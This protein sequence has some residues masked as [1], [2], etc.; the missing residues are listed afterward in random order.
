MILEEMTKKQ[1]KKE[2]S[3]SLYYG[4]KTTA[5]TLA[6]AGMGVAAGIAGIAVAAAVGEIILPVALCLWSTGVAGGALG[7]LLGAKKKQKE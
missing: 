3:D 7:L 2:D 6:G 5:S 4:L 1:D